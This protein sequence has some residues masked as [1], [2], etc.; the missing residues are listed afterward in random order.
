M[1]CEQDFSKDAEGK[2]LHEMRARFSKDAF[3]KQRLSE[4]SFAESYDVS[5]R[6]SCLH[7]VKHLTKYLSENLAH[8]LRSIFQRIL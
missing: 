6:E 4:A 1:R 3:G 2:T 8:I 7:L 5:F